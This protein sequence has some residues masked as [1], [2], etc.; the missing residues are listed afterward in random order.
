[1]LKFG[2]TYLNY[3]GTYFTGWKV[4]DPLNPYDL[5]PN[6]IRVRTN[7]G[8]P[9]NRGSHT[10]YETATLVAG[11]TDVY[12]V[13]KSNNLF[14]F[15]LA[16]CSNLVEILGGNTTNVIN[17]GAAFAKCPNLVS[18]SI[19]DTS[20]VTDMSEMFSQST[21]LTTVP[22]FNTS[23]VTGMNYMFQ[24]CSSL[25]NVPLF[26]TSKVV[27]M[28]RMFSYCTSL[29]SVPLFDTLKVKTT[30]Q[31]FL[32][33]TALTAIPQLILIGEY[34]NTDQMFDNCSNVESGILDYYN[35]LKFL[36]D[37]YLSPS[38]WH[39]FRNCGINTQTGAAELA[40]IPD[41]WK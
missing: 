7:D 11:T 37:S 26:D 24:Y 9:P 33:C 20:N 29:T 1:M 16:D 41:D 22:L 38:H 5:P 40:Q 30:Y 21:S 18:V 17:M 32:N 31:M 12:D 2:N 36:E 13:Y 3:N 10:S 34:I 25:T 19:F 39:T 28:G 8:N 35:Y 15:L 23:N 27:D 6:T 14:D 4:F